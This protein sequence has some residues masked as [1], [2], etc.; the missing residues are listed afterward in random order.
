MVGDRQ[1]TRPPSNNGTLQWLGLATTAAVVITMTSAWAGPSKSSSSTT[2]QEGIK[3]FSIVHKVLTSPRCANCHPVDDVPTVGDDMR[4]HAMGIT[5]LSP[6]SG[7]PCSSCHR[8]KGF[9][10]PMA[11]LPPAAPHWGLPPLNQVFA[12][13]TQ[14]ELCAQLNE[15]ETTGGRDLDALLHHVREDALVLWGW[16]PGEGRLPVATSHADFVD[17]FATW[18]ASGGACPEG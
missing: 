15:P 3:A 2:K 10:L 6:D 5:R 9:V 11:N 13:R 14:A 1:Q 8:D 12:G 18:V 16:A 7:L 4:P 17:A